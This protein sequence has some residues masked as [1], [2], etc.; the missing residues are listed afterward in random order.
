VE[1]GGII[2][3]MMCGSTIC[4]AVWEIPVSMR[5]GEQAGLTPHVVFRENDWRMSGHR[6]AGMVVMQNAQTD[7]L[8]QHAHDVSR[9]VPKIML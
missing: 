4:E 1:Y 7:P 3:D 6:Y 8:L 9:I 2:R 5:N